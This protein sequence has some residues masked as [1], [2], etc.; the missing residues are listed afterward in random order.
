M[1]H[2]RLKKSV[3]GYDYLTKERGISTDT[4][5]R[6]LIGFV[7]MDIA[8]SFLS[9]IDETIWT[10]PKEYY[11]EMLCGRVL[12]PI[13]DD[14]GRVIGV[15]TKVPEKGSK[16]WWNSIFKKENILYGLN[17]AKNSAFNT[18]KIYLVEGYADAITLWQAGL[19]NVVAVM[20]T[21]FTPVQQG[22]VLRYCKNICICFDTDPETASGGLGGGQ[23][24]LQKIVNNYDSAGYFGVMSAIVLP[25][26]DDG[27]G[28]D[29]DSFVKK[30]GIKSYLDLERRILLY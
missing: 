10:H 30:F 22:L 15:S 5:K 9:E 7:D 6:E 16:G 28:E 12:L 21:A 1:S 3:V 2:D 17:R 4:I 14:C 29:P 26:S 11:M 20:G 8:R 27:K 19:L 18:D 23:K 25:L 24:G 13:R